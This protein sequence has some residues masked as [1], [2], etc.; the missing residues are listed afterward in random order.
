METI[1]DIEYSSTQEEHEKMTPSLRYSILQRD[2][3]RCVL[4]DSTVED[5]GV[6]LH[7][8]HIMPISKGGKTEPSNLRT[9][10]DRC[11]FGKGARYNPYGLN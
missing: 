10:C 9:L 3:F 7:A 1:P 5:N 8:G 4:C 2:G 6:K 11:T